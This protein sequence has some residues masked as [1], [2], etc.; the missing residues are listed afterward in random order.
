MI[1]FARYFHLWD[2]LSNVKVRNMEVWDSY[3]LVAICLTALLVTLAL[4]SRMYAA[5]GNIFYSIWHGNSLERIEE[6]NSMAR[7][8][9]FVAILL[10]L[11]FSLAAINLHGRILNEALP[12]PVSFASIVVF[13]GLLLLYFSKTLVLT[14]MD[15]VNNTNVFFL[16]NKIFLSY[17]ILF[18][19]LL[20]PG[21]A[22]L[23]TVDG[24]SLRICEYYC[25]ADFFITFF[26]YSHKSYS[27]LKSKGFSIN[28]WILYL[29]ILEILPA[30][31]LVLAIGY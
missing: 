1:K 27:L 25:L 14:I 6:N 9:N 3:V 4:F 22:V 2:T 8:R 19:L 15:W 7:S 31:A 13:A 23:Y 11:L 20:L 26:L 12:V 16:L 30:V 29:C 18:A 17:S 5:I 28:F 10:A 21:V 24:I